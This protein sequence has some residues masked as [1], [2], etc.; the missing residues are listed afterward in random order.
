MSLSASRQRFGLNRQIQ[1][2]ETASENF[3]HTLAPLPED[4]ATRIFE[5]FLYDYVRDDNKAIIDTRIKSLQR[6]SQPGKLQTKSLV[7]NQG[8]NTLRVSGPGTGGSNTFSFETEASLHEAKER[9]EAKQEKARQERVKEQAEEKAR[10]QE[11]ARVVKVKQEKAR[12]QAEARAR[13]Q[14]E[15]RIDKAKRQAEANA[16]RGAKAREAKAKKQAEAK[17]IQQA[18]AKEEKARKLAEA[19]QKKAEIK[20]AREEA[21]QRRAEEAGAGQA[22]DEEE[23]GEEEAEESEE[24]EE[25]EEVAAEEEEEEEAEVEQE[26]EVEEEE[27]EEEEEEEDEEMAHEEPDDEAAVQLAETANASSESAITRAGPGIAANRPNRPEALDQAHSTPSKSGEQ[28]AHGTLPPFT[29]TQA[30]ASSRS[31]D[32][33]GITQLLKA[34][35]IVDQPLRLTNLVISAPSLQ[36]SI[37]V[38]LRSPAIRR[39]KPQLQTSIPRFVRSLFEPER[40]WTLRNVMCKIVNQCGSRFLDTQQP[41]PQPGNNSTSSI[42]EMGN[43]DGAPP[44]FRG[45]VEHWRSTQRWS[46]AAASV[47]VAT[48]MRLYHDMHAFMCWSR[49]KNVWLKTRHDYNPKEKKGHGEDDGDDVFLDS[50]LTLAPEEEQALKVF[51]DQLLHRRYNQA[52]LKYSVAATTRSVPLLKQL[53]APF[54]G[55]IFPFDA[56]GRDPSAR[57]AAKCFNSSWDMVHVRGKMNYTLVRHLGCGAFS[58]ARV[59]D[60]KHLGS[61]AL[62]IVCRTLSQEY[63]SLLEAFRTLYDVYVAPTINGNLLVIQRV[64]TYMNIMTPEDLAKVCS[65]NSKGLVGIFDPSYVV[66]APEIDEEQAATGAVDY[67]EESMR[68]SVNAPGPMEHR[69]IA[70]AGLHTPPDSTRRRRDPSD[71]D[72]AGIARGAKRRGNREMI[73]V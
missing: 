73:S 5:S 9:E 16:I 57:Q 6:C 13:R 67:S 38:M 20:K 39:L 69:F 3:R 42:T 47:D 50:D 4:I 35:N 2:A 49:I 70:P 68:S 41:A 18:K 65:K 1:V 32:E 61:D 48:L 26:E 11:E 21:K 30:H 27:P 17:A 52:G 46:Q 54:L 24:E 43:L 23:E 55:Y 56:Q 29:P 60:L 45:L 25:E 66:E 14:E 44:C 71:E 36:H 22:E 58:I 31:A 72:A 15:A 40:Y 33:L 8:S 7:Y 62:S 59:S 64:N 51:F 10:Q 28:S 63:P 12:Q 19:Q 34:G 37:E 53:I